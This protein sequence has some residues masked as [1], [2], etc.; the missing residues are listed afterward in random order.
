MLYIRYKSDIEKLLHKRSKRFWKYHEHNLEFSK[1]ANRFCKITYYIEVISVL[2]CTVVVILYFLK[3]CFNRDNVFLFDTWT[4]DS[5]VFSTILLMSQ[6]YVF[7]LMTPTVFTYD[8]I[9]LSLCV[10]VILQTKLLRR[11]FTHFSDN[12]NVKDALAGY[13]KHHQ[14]LTRWVFHNIFISLNRS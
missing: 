14:F 1:I 12:R 3:P 7:C 11:E 8:V 4:L 13:I 9:Y 10:D 5:I 6:Y 2:S